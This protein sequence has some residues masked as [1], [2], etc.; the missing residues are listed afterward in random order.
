VPEP[1]IEARQ[2]EKFYD[3]PSDNRIQVIAPLDLAVYP[4]EILTLLGPSG[5]GKSTLLRIL[6][7]LSPASAGQVLWH[8]SPVS[9]PCEN[10]AIVFQSFALFPWLT[11]LENIEAPLKARGVSPEGRFARSLRMADAVGLDGFENAY[12][13][14][15]SGGMKQ[16]V[17]FARAL[18]VEPEVLF[19]DEPFSALDVL[20][21]ENLRSELLELWEDKKMPTRAVFIVT[22][23]IEEAV[24][25]GDRI[26]VLGKNPGRIRTNF[27]VDLPRP[28]DRKQPRFTRIVDY[29][30][31][32]LTKPDTEH[33]LPATGPASGSP[34]SDSRAKYPM[35]PHARTG[36]IAGFLEILA[37]HNGREDVYRLADLL[38]FEIDDLLPIVE[39]AALL[40][41]VKLAEGDVEITPAGLEF[42][43][44]D[45]LLQKELFRNAALEHVALLKQIKRSLESKSDHTLPDEFFHDIL[46]EHF[47]EEETLRQLETAINWG[48]Y[49]ELFD[50]DSERKRFFIP[51]EAPVAPESLEAGTEA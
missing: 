36:G 22:H 30:Y 26:V 33:A 29:I 43:N 46:D 34:A 23:N 44:A 47:S 18:V 51:E 2:V 10:V 28:R 50:H 45:I 42:T 38:S 40:G 37:D 41:F 24:L 32:V 7:G 13:K 15:L 9:G 21:A 49:A 1:L 5:S 25:L 39:G 14:E 11:V 48:R 16:R 12:P 17:G 31:Q 27:N 6:T 19:M 20:T 8:G 4:G 3:Q 35:L